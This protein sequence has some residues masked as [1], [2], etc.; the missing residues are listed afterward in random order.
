[1]K[2]FRIFI[3]AFFAVS[4]IACGGAE[5]RKAVYLEKA[6]VS[7]AAGD[8]DKARIE[9]KNVLQI[10]PKDAEAYYQLGKVFEAQ[11]EYR[12]AFSNFLKAE[13][14]DP[15]LLANQA[16][17]GKIYLIFTN[18]LDKAQGKIDFILSKEPDNAEG[19]L[20]K[21]V[22][23]LKKK[24]KS[25]AIKIAQDVVAK[26][27]GHVDAT[28]FLA[29]L[30]ISENRVSDAVVL[31]DN[32]LSNN[33]DNERL[34]RY[35]VL[36]LVKNKDFDRAEALYIKFMKRNPDSASSYNNLAAFYNQTDN[37]TKAEKIL[38]AS[39][40][41]DPSDVARQLTLVKY[42]MA[43]KGKDETINELRILISEN[44]SLGELRLA[45]GEVYYKSGNKDSAIDIYANAINDFSDEVT[46]IEAGIALI[47]IYLNDRQY[48]NAGK[49]IEKLILVSP[50]DPKVNFL[51]AKLAIHEKDFEKAIISLRIVTK[52][53]PEN[54]DAFLL[55]AGVYKYEENEEQFN[56]TL[57]SA[58]DNNKT[59]AEGLLKLARYQMTRNI[60][61]A[62]KIIDNY[63]NIKKLD[64][65]GLSIKAGILNQKKEQAEAYKIAE[66]LI[67]SFPDK[68]NGYLQVLPYY[69]LKGERGKAISTLE[70]GY[71][72][73]KDKRKILLLLT[74][75]QVLERQFDI[76]LKRVK[77]E[78]SV[79]P[80]DAELKFLLSKIYIVSN[81][82]GSAK[83][84]LKDL[85]NDN[86]KWIEP[87]MLLSDLYIR[88]K[89]LNKAESILISGEKNTESS[90]K[91][92]L[93]LAALYELN[94]NYREAINIYKKLQLSNSENHIV[95]NNLV[96]LLSDHGDNN[97]L[98]F[99]KK[100]IE[101]LKGED[102][103]VFLDT[104]GWFYYNISDYKTAVQYLVRVVD[105]EPKINVFNYHMGMAYKMSGD[106]AQAK[107]YLEKSLS[108]GKN[109]KEKEL[110]KSVLKNL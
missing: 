58:F 9:L 86:P 67:E 12:K 1:M 15:E 48:D 26:H 37:K 73:V 75:L 50:G 109:F 13:V 39:I 57:N 84:I 40:E 14:L 33:K 10:D 79:S 28:T 92:S 17:L 7:I 25:E 65:E 20:L 106:T 3:L 105:K 27:P 97:D 99:A 77:A 96:S 80:K 90:I 52:E 31:V 71:N 100:L 56:S 46:E 102:Q 91:V 72:T 4:L 49:V 34:N 82:I 44:K 55:L 5:E 53:T 54:I 110:A 76:A 23:M 95:I 19:L 6:K 51:R 35:L 2:L 59:N 8:L 21:A 42:I 88:S 60:N 81:D 18:D 104:I 89:D 103:A 107:I 32:A 101:K 64:Y 61:Q 69:S 98:N 74:K 36:V 29:S 43:T 22:M 70:K 78:I 87:Y 38:R 24:D 45:L 94:E 68:P 47:S 85:I 11:K 62:E 41:N 16:Q 93:K 30:Y 83:S 108:D 63:N 66:V